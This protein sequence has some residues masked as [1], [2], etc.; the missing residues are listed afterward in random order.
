MGP[1]SLEQVLREDLKQF[2][3][4]E[5]VK[6]RITQQERGATHPAGYWNLYVASDPE[7]DSASGSSARRDFVE[8]TVCK[9][10]DREWI[11]IDLMEEL[12]TLNEDLHK[13]TITSTGEL[14]SIYYLDLRQV[15]PVPGKGPA[16]LNKVCEIG[17]GVVV[18]VVPGA[19]TTAAQGCFSSWWDKAR[20]RLETSHPHTNQVEKDAGNR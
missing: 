1:L 16:S 17:L 6:A 10:P 14:A 18:Q 13:A 12:D 7:P 19:A 8:S 11:L 5:S 3:E 2:F 4:R 15:V 9:V 20:K